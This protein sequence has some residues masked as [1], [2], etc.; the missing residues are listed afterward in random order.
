MRA[1]PADVAERLRV[2]AVDLDPE[3]VEVGDLAQDLQVAFGL[4][5]EIAV[6]QDVD[7]RACAVADRFQVHAQVAQDLAVD[8]D[9]RLEGRAEAGPPAAR[10]AVVIGED[11]GLERG[12]LLLAYLAPHGLDAIEVLDRRFVPGGMIDPPG[13][14]MRPVD[15]NAI[16][17]PAAE[18]LVAGHA[19]TLGLGIEKRVLD[20]AERLRD[21]AAGCGPRG[22]IQ[23]GMNALVL[24]H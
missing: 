19:E 18:K 2:E 10:L 13:G 21:H 7:I 22:S 15:S 4:G 20:R 16:P 12:E 24:E 1:L 8:I 23:L 3:H 6:E 14:A 11:V 17:D 9:L 5:V